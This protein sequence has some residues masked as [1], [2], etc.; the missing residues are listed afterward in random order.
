MKKIFLSVLVMTL[1]LTGVFPF[2]KNVAQAD[3]S[4]E[5][6]QDKL[7]DLL[8]KQ[9][10]AQAELAAEQSKLY[11]NKSQIAATQALMK[12][13]EAD[14]KRQEEELGNL[15]DR[16]ESNKTML[17]EYLRQIYYTD[18]ADA[19]T[20][21]AMSDANLD[22]LS[23]GYDRMVDI[24]NKISDAIEVINDA[25]TEAQLAKEKL[26][27][28]NQ[29]TKQQLA[30]QQVQQSQ[31][32]DNIQ[33][34]QSDIADLQKKFAE[35]Q[36]DLNKL[37]GSNY[38]AKDI[39]DA[40]KY[41]SDKTDVPVGFLVGVLKMETNLGANVGGC[42]YAQV[43]DGAEANYKK[44]KLGKTA[45]N[46]FQ[47]RRKTFKAICDELDLNYQKQKVSCNPS[48]YAGTG[49]AMGVAQFMPDTWNAYKSQVSSVTGHDNPSPW[50]LTDGVVAMALKLSRTPGVTSGK[51]SA[52]RLAAKYYLGT[53]Y[54]PYI[55]GII[56]WSKHYKDLI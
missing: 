23:S 8:K 51:E 41:A 17:A 45:W 19:V 42:T 5:K 15:N 25:K 43:E 28:Q 49:G 21:L 34:T 33:D 27:D 13:L 10:E 50:N 32:V 30:T 31:I 9:K 54:K 47:A 56:Y 36:S 11:K 20:E 35:L 44:G 39:K 12:S 3:T 52:F 4:A 48:G 7:D 37:L 24:K 14:I 26:A 55:D 18:S 16:A 1:V 22:E 40:V 46:T 6:I 53:S 38:D 2:S 29:D